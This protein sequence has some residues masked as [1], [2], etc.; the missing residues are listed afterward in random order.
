[1]WT[2][3]GGE[4]PAK[5]LL[6]DKNEGGGEAGEEVECSRAFCGEGGPDTEGIGTPLPLFATAAFWPPSRRM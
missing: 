1:M 3:E 5:T 2:G 4:V 6:R